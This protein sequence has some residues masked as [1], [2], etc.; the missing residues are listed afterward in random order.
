MQNLNYEFTKYQRL[1]DHVHI[2]NCLFTKVAMCD[3][4][5][6]LYNY[7]M[8]NNMLCLL[9]QAFAKECTAFHESSSIV[10]PECYIF[11]LLIFTIK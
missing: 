8:S 10:D 11:L 4:K 6:K 9:C 2:F 1:H 5:S 3:R 7:V